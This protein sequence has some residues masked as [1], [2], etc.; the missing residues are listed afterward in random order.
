M[1]LASSST[2]LLSS[3][4]T[5]NFCFTLNN[6]TA[7]D[8]VMYK[9]LAC[10]YVRFSQETAPGTGTPHLQGFAIF[11]N[12]MT[13]PNAI[14]RFHGKP[15]V[16]VMKGTVE[17]NME[18]CSKEGEMHEHGVPPVSKKEQGDKEKD[19]WAEA[20]QLTK[21]GRFEEV[22]P[23][24][25][26][27]QARNMDF[28]YSRT[29]MKDV[30][31]DTTDQ[32]EW[33]Y[34]PTRTGK[35]RKAR[36]LY[37]EAYLKMCN[38]WWDGYTHQ[39]VVLL[40]DFDKDHECL[41]HHLKIWGDRYSFIGERKGAALKIRPKKIIVTSNWHPSEIWSAAASLEPILA[42]FKCT[43]FG[44]DAA[45][46][47]ATKTSGPLFVHPEAAPWAGATVDLSTPTNTSAISTTGT[48][49]QEI[50]ASAVVDL[51][52]GSDDDGDHIPFPAWQLDRGEEG[53]G[54]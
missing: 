43:K 21:A 54:E 2:V 49:T 12:P 17:Q 5:R 6:Y 48:G 18:Y 1:S 27:T 34:G 35:S 28:I 25:Q 15:H 47:A 51:V 23:Q 30:L 4:R 33:W 26:F 50:A 14:K 44:N 46:Q 53:E 13:L 22:D 37:P 38:K 52:G 3:A 29:Q 20:L 11:E 39:D 10:K 45:L 32:M 31:A 36:T 8:L 9:H 16:E 24:I 40:E 42:R 41:G 19:R 7:D